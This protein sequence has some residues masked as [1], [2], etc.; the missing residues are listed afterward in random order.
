M[1][2][3]EI[4]LDVEKIAKEIEYFI[5]LSKYDL[6][7]AD[8]TDVV[9]FPPGND[10]ANYPE[11]AKLS[12]QFK[13]VFDWA[14]EHQSDEDQT[15]LEATMDVVEDWIVKIQEKINEDEKFWADLRAVVIPLY[16]PAKFEKKKDG[17]IEMKEEGEN[18]F[19]DRW[20]SVRITYDP[21]TLTVKT[22]YKDPDGTVT[23][24]KEQEMESGLNVEIY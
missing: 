24:E 15:E 6:I 14:E 13:A 4:S 10:E 5:D 7:N 20:K 16:Q 8:Q 3:P 22:T 9:C 17:K 21:D 1:S 19:A 11:I 12:V 23:G 18:E 2:A